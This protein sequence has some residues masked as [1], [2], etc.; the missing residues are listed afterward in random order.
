MKEVT[1]VQHRTLEV[2]A[3]LTLLHRRT[4]SLQEIATVLRCSRVAVFY[5]LHWLEKKGLWSGNART[6]TESG[7]RSAFDAL[8][9]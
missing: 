6:I 3:G 9:R 4:P 8:T 7:L 5:R 1:E 2:V